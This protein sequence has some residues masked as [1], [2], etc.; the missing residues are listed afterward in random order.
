MVAVAMANYAR[1]RCNGHSI[2]FDGAAFSE[3]G[4]GRDTLL[5]EA[6]GGEGVYMACVD[7]DALRAYRERS[8]WGNAYRRPSLYGELSAAEA[9][10]PLKRRADRR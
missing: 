4:K 9:A 8:V 10:M 1:P 5:V 2:A 7:L 3:E 6:G